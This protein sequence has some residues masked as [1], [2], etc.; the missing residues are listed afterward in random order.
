MP[1]APSPIP[2]TDLDASSLLP[3]A[4]PIPTTPSAAPKDGLTCGYCGKRF[5][6]PSKLTEHLRIHTGERPFP[7]PYC[8]Y[9]ATQRVNY[10]KHVAAVHSV[11]L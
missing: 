3:Q 2:V 9:R 10:R 8:P 1:P 4:F 7:C 5:G 6:F 11:P